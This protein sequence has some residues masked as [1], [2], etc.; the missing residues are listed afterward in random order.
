M[1]GTYNQIIQTFVWPDQRSIE[2]QQINKTIS[3]DEVLKII[4]IYNPNYAGI[5]G[6]TD[7]GF[8]IEVLETTTTIVLEEIFAQKTVTIEAG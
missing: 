5:F 4:G 1:T 3:T 2:C 7:Q 8:V 6:N